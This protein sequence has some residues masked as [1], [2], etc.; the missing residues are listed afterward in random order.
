[1]IAG[2]VSFGSACWWAR[3]S[4]IFDALDVALGGA[5]A[6]AVVGGFGGYEAVQWFGLAAP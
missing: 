2:V 1:M 5:V 3:R 6:A 4:R